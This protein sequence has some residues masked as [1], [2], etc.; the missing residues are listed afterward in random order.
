MERQEIIEAL[1]TFYFKSDGKTNAFNIYLFQWN[2]KYIPQWTVTV[3]FMKPGMSVWVGKHDKELY[4]EI[5]KIDVK[6]V[7]KVFPHNTVITS[8]DYN[9][10][11][12]ELT[13][14]FVNQNTGIRTY[15]GVPRKLFYQLYYLQSAADLLS[16]YSKNFK[17]KF[18][19]KTKK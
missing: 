11:I 13:I 19:L 5:F 18:D 14:N 6:M 12:S 4:W 9:G 3:D 8:V 10:E 16:F 1:L 2:K 15:T 7:T 17:G